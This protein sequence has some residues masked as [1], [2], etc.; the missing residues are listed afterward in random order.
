MKWYKIICLAISQSKES[1]QPGALLIA[2]NSAD[3]DF[4]SALS[5]GNIPEGGYINEAIH[6]GVMLT[7]SGEPSVKQAQAFSFSVN[8]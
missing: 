3:W 5:Y 8:W 2:Q 4:P 6:F 1:K 7:Y